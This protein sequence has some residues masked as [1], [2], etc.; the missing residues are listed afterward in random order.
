M[1][2]VM[3][4]IG[5]IGLVC[6]LIFMLKRSTN[7][8]VLLDRLLSLAYAG[9]LL[10]AVIFG[11]LHRDEFFTILSAINSFCVLLAI[12]FANYSTESRLVKLSGLGVIVSLCVGLTSIG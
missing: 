3:E 7:Y 4:I 9:T 5:L 11:V 6:S 10:L 1:S 8:T 12:L 2:D